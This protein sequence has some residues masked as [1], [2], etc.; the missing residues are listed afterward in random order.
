MKRVGDLWEKITSIENIEEAHKKASEDKSYYRD[1]RMV[2]SDP[3]YYLKEVQR[4][5]VEHEYEVS[6]Y[7]VQMI[8]DKGK[9]RELMKLK[10]F[11]DR[12]IQWAIMLQLEPV[13]N[14]TFCFHTCASIPERGSKKVNRLL[15]EY[16]KDEEG[17]KF[18]YKFDVRKFY[19]HVNYRILKRLLRKKIKDR[20]LLWLLDLI[21]DSY[22]GEV[23]L[24]IGSYLS[25]YLAN[26]YLAYF[27]HYLKEELGLKYVVRYMDDVVILAES[28]EKLHTIHEKVVAYLGDN[29][30][31]E[32]KGNWQIFPVD[33]RGIDFVGYRHFHGFRLLRKST[34]K[35]M[36]K[37][38]Y[39]VFDKQIGGKRINYREW[40]AINSYVGWLI[41]CDSWRLYHKHIE[42]IMWS[43]FRYYI[44]IICRKKHHVNNP[45]K[46]TTREVMVSFERYAR[47]FEKKKGRC[48]A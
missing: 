45:M 48:A 24:P 14:R 3:D 30:E 37:L 41:W 34:C 44:E 36:K 39:L 32:L 27:D 12:I 21:I 2:N 25:Q 13:F 1:V 33:A 11:P 26:F 29:L 22:P 23:G 43:V 5:L 46:N 31:L 20:E 40:C 7:I 6:E 15:E 42:P 9:D 28:K 4:L 16:L 17:T 47:K 19:P 10:Y 38:C 18:C 8:W 35:R